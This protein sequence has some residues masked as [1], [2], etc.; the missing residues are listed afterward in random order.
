LP[1]SINAE[2][3]EYRWKNNFRF[4]DTLPVPEHLLE[5]VA[6]RKPG[7]RTNGHGGEPLATSLAEAVKKIAAAAPG[8]RHG[9]LN[10]Q[11]YGIGKA[12]AA[13]RIDE[14]E[15]RA[16]LI[17]T[18]IA[19]MGAD[20]AA[21][22]ERTVDEALAAGKQAS[23]LPQIHI[24]PGE[25]PRVVTEAEDALLKLEPDIYQ[26][27]GLV[28]RPVLSRLKAADDRDTQGWRLIQVTLPHMVET[29]TCAAE[30]MRC[31]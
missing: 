17:E 27:G 22:A 4:A 6:K 12:I 30:F 20:R 2:G 11:A 29:L 26:R 21:E 16:A 5:Y 28:V 23:A 3:K 25:L 31:G 15:A 10:K 9:E 19:A 13:G 14:A 7:Q 18:G 24:L 8:H 1:G